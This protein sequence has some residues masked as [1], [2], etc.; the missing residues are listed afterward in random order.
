MV[1][2]PD[3]GV[4]VP[5]PGVGV[6]DGVGVGAGLLMITSPPVPGEPM[7]LGPQPASARALQPT[8]NKPWIFFTMGS[9]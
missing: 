5:V 3:A 7:S 1:G 6:G 2:Q 4:T 8:S 9:P